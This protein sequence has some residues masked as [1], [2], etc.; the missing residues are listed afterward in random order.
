VE[1]TLAKE[2]FISLKIKVMKTKRRPISKQHKKNK[3]LLNYITH[4]IHKKLK[5]KRKNKEKIKINV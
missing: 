3:N 1:I 4:T 2:K 5:K